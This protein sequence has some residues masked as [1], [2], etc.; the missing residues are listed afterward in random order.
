MRA[1]IRSDDFNRLIG[2]TKSFLSVN[3][4]RP[5]TRYIRL[6]FNAETS[7]VTA[8][9][10]D[11][12]RMSVE[13]SVC[14][15]DE[16]FV[17]YIHGNVKL[18]CGLEAEI[19]VS[20]GETTIRCGDFI[21]GCP[22]KNGEFIDWKSVISPPGDPI[23]RI[24]F[25]G[26]YLLSALQAAKISNGNSF[27]KPIILEFRGPTLPVLFRTNEDDVKIVLPIRIKERT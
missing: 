22:I 19:K 18:P 9:A 5:L 15:C 10:V 7:Q 1:T 26:N 14:A 21:F 12:Y 8:I 17:T 11:G 25:N 27:R 23:L 2:A 13:H 24:G 3:S 4:V 16:D 20:D 6:E